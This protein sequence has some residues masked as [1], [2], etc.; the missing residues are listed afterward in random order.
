MTTIGRTLNSSLAGDVQGESAAAQRTFRMRQG[1]RYQRASMIATYAILLFA[2]FYILLPFVWLIGSS[3]KNTVQFYAVPIVWIPNPLVWQN[4]LRVFQLY[5]FGHYI[6]NSVWLAVVCSTAEVFS[7]A[8][9]AYG[10]ARFKFPGR[11][12]LFILVLSTLMIPSQILTI[13]LYINFRALG[14][15]DTFWPIIVPHLFGSA[16]LIFIFRQFFLGLPTELDEAGRI[17]GCSSFGVLWRIILPQSRPVF[18][19]AYV[20]SFLASWRDAWGPLI[21]LNSDQNRTLPLGLLDFTTPTGQDYP[22]LMAATVIALAIPVVLY[23]IGQRYID[24]GLAI[25]DIR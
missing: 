6:F 1:F 18:V 25:A 4:Y 16:F 14:W 8:F 22:A 21:Y 10:F 23:A 3:L 19:V 24:S 7:S 13:S 9:V 5:S 2:S 17:D 15:I 12:T 11:N 20:F